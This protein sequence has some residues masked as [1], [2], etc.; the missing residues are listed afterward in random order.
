MFMYLTPH[1]MQDAQ[2]HAIR[3]WVPPRF[4][5]NLSLGVHKQLYVP[6][7]GHTYTPSI[8][9]QLPCEKYLKGVHL[10]DGFIQDDR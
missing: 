8:R 1:D 10:E 7:S 4:P 2:D 5:S 3:K 9:A 6:L